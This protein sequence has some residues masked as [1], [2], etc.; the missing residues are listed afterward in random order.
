MLSQIE[1]KGG[2]VA[3]LAAGMPQRWIA[4]EA[5]RRERALVSGE[6]LKVGVNIYETDDADVPATPRAMF[7]VDP[8][9]AEHQIA[10]TRTRR[11]ARGTE[12]QD[13]LVGL[14]EAIAGGDNVMPAL[15]NAARQRATLGEMSDVFREAFGE[16][17]EPSPW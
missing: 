14:R 16:F 8:E 1:D 3:A 10:R 6:V 17:E 15:I 12:A 5:Y 11:R 2:A 4:E 13:A 9:V 7:A